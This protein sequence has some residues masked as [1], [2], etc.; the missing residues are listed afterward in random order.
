M[1]QTKNEWQG[2]AEVT[3]FNQTF[4]EVAVGFVIGAVLLVAI[5]VA[6]MIGDWL[7]SV[8]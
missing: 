2:F 7:Q 6:N 4:K 8:I 5:S 3:G 1:K